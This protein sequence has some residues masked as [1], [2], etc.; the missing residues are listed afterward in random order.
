[1][2]RILCTIL[3]SVQ[4]YVQSRV[5]YKLGV[6]LAKVL[7]VCLYRR[8]VRITKVANV[9]TTVGKLICF[10]HTTL[11]TQNKRQE[12]CQKVAMLHYVLYVVRQFTT[13]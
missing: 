2:K 1:M 12:K 11:A 10:V 13:C 9:V 8:E 7:Y 6:G 4:L 3:L 5:Q